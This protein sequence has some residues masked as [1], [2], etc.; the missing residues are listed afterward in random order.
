MLMGNNRALPF[1]ALPQTK[2]Y[3]AL[4]EGARAWTKIFPD[5]FG[6]ISRRLRLKKYLNSLSVGLTLKK[7]VCSL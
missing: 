3:R 4:E 2:F 1:P 6:N 7:V 5:N